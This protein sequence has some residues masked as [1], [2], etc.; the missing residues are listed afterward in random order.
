MGNAGHYPN[1][2]T[3]RNEQALLQLPYIN[4]QEGKYEL[5][6]EPRSLVGVMYYLSHAVEVPPKH[7]Q[8]GLVTVSEY[9]WGEPFDWRLVTGDLFQVRFHS[10]EAWPGD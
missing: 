10:P 3:E 8:L 7:A 1:G 6:L 5:E 4:L 9:P 2:L